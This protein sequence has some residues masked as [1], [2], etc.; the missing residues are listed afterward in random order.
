MGP[1]GVR[2]CRMRPP[3]LQSRGGVDFL[4]ETPFFK[5]SSL[6]CHVNIIIC[7]KGLALLID[8]IALLLHYAFHDTA[9]VY[10]IQLC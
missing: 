10:C 1:E 5:M 4:P 3:A 7:F 2:E 6:S 9:W 8:F